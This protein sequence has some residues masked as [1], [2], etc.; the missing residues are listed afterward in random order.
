[1]VLPLLVSHP[2]RKKRGKSGA[3]YVLVRVLRSATPPDHGV[4]LKI[5]P[6]LPLPPLVV[7]P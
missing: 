3:P 2:F 5:T 6:L 7:A 4:I 1:M